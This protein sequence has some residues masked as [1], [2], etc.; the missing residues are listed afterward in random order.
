[1]DTSSDR[2][3]AMANLFQYWLDYQEENGY[4]ITDD[5]HFRTPPEYPT[6]GTLKQWVKILRESSEIIDKSTT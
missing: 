3:K 4:V 1:M 2:L 6:R 5:T